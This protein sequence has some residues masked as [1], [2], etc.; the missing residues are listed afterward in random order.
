MYVSISQRG[1]YKFVDGLESSL[2]RWKKKH[3]L[4]SNQSKVN[5]ASTLLS[6]SLTSA[7]KN[8][9]PSFKDLTNLKT[10]QRN[11]GPIPTTNSFK[12]KDPK[13][14]PPSIATTSLLFGNPLAIFL[15]ICQFFHSPNQSSFS[16]LFSSFFMN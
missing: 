8:F 16:F 12:L 6:F 3:S 4:S 15:S 1:G 11:I 14:L 7:P 13:L 9:P 10:F 5:S 2:K